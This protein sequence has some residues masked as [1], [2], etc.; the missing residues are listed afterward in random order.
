MPRLCSKWG[1][2]LARFTPLVNCPMSS[3]A[4]GVSR[5]PRAGSTGSPGFTLIELMVVVMIVSVLAVMAVPSLSHENYDRRAYTDAASV[6]ELVREARTRAVGHG[7]AELLII[8]ALGTSNTADFQ[9]WESTSGTTTQSSC[10]TPTT[11]PTYPVSCT[12]PGV[13]PVTANCIDEF[14]IAP[15]SA[16]GQSVEALGL[17][18]MLGFNAAGTAATAP[19]YICFTPA[20]RTYYSTT[21]ATNSFNSMVSACSSD[22]GASCV[23]AM[24][25]NVA[26][27]TMAAAPG[28]TSPTNVVRTVW[29]PPSGSTSITSQ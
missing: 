18:N 24:T 28:G 20:G 25:V 8:N 5:V 1:T 15:S 27:G 6:A 2:R 13:A 11:W 10:N 12:S 14:Q 17:I 29:I 7:A 4:L 3:R 21:G 23:G 9:L 19:M 22:A 26:A 16:S